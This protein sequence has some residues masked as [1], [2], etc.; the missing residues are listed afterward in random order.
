MALTK[1]TSTFIDTISSTQ[2]LKSGAIAGD[3][4]SF[5]GPSESWK[6]KTPT[7]GGTVLS[8]ALS[9]DGSIQLAGSPITASGT[10]GVSISSVALN[11]IARGGAT[12]G[13]ALTWD[14]STNTWKASALPASAGTVTNVI[15][16]SPDS[17]LQ[18][19]GSPIN[20]TGTLGVSIL[21]VG[22]NKLSTTGAALGN[23]IAYNGTNWAVDN[24]MYIAAGKVGLG[25]T[26]PGQLLTVNGNLDNTGGTLFTGAVNEKAFSPTINNTDGVVELHIGA[27]TVFNISLTRNLTK[28]KFI[29]RP[30]TTGVFTVTL[31]LTQDAT[32]GRAVAWAYEIGGVA[33]NIKWAQ[34][35]VPTMTTTAGKTDI[36]SF[37]SSDGGT[38][39][40]GFIGGQIF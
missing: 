26:A 17:S 27:A 31:V 33:G 12:Q 32:G 36:Y 1:V 19:T 20:N 7:T 30:V 8:V 23:L 6:P 39:W 18:V 22:L 5:D 2:I 13:Q 9:S 3:V 37:F 40:F 38:N 14:T 24:T 21:N 11:K 10:L 25:T 4:L 16:N 15:M 35:F 29:N 28:F 34:G